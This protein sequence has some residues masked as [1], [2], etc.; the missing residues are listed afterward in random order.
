MSARR[1]GT[2][3]N[4]VG[5]R[6]LPHGPRRKTRLYHAFYVATAPLLSAARRLF[7]GDVLS[8]E[9]IGRAIL[10]AAESG[11]TKRVL[12]SADIRAPLMHGLQI[13]RDKH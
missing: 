5:Q 9:E 12:E 7:P 4:R 1:A 6:Y 13:S 3:G 8:T 2:S 11:A 10:K